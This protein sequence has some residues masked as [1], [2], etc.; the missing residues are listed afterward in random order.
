[1]NSG[2]IGRDYFLFKYHASQPVK[3]PVDYLD[4]TSEEAVKT[5]PF[6][7]VVLKEYRD[8]NIAKYQI[9]DAKTFE[10]LGYCNDP[11][12]INID[13]YTPDCYVMDS[14][15]FIEQYRIVPNEQE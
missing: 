2:Y 15:S 4:V 14:I 13:R 8:P 7:D 1:V 10:H 12:D 9:L 6:R 5:L 11:D 3:Q